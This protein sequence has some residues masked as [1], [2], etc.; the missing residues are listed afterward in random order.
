MIRKLER[1]QRDMLTTVRGEGE[2][3]DL[4]RRTRTFLKISARGILEEGG[5][6]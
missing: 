1:C 6:V 3:A 2:V 4:W 5:E